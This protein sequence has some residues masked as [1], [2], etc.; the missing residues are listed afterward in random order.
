MVYHKI[1][2]LKIKKKI[3]HV[4]KYIYIYERV[5]IKKCLIIIYQKLYNIDNNIILIYHTY[6][7]KSFRSYKR[8]KFDKTRLRPR[9]YRYT[10][11]WMIFSRECIT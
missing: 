9:T 10:D 6:M 11:L 4:Y 8:K 3:K 7:S 5:R 1:I 2:F